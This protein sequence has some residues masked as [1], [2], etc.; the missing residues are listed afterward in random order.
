VDV[1]SGGAGGG[2]CDPLHATTT[3]TTPSNM[4]KERFT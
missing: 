3:G 2:A 1:D 4:K